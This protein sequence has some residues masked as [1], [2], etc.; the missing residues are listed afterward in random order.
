M[1]A[2]LRAPLTLEQLLTAFHTLE[3]E[4]AELREKLE[5][6]RPQPSGDSGEFAGATGVDANGAPTEEP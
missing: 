4:N 2:A 1:I 5:R 3:D 6:L